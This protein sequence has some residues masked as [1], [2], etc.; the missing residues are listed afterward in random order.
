METSIRI[1]PFDDLEQSLGLGC[2]LPL[3]IPRAPAAFTVWL[4]ER[5]RVYVCAKHAGD[6]QNLKEALSHLRSVSGWR[7]PQ[8]ASS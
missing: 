2:Q 1:D 6:I 4:D 3:C 5:S 7:S 8:E